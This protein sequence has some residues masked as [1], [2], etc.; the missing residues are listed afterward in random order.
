[1]GEVDL[2]LSVSEHVRPVDRASCPRPRTLL[3][4]I[5][6][7][8]NAE[9]C[10]TQDAITRCVKRLVQHYPSF[11]M[12]HTIAVVFVHCPCAHIHFLV[13]ILLPEL[14]PG[15]RLDSTRE[16]KIPT[17]AYTWIKCL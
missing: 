3:L 9:D 17:Y 16:F 5:G 4:E 7:Q 8:S 6:R 13:L 1:V 11:T 14:K 10:N 2:R 12:H 15:C